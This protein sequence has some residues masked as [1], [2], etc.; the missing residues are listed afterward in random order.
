MTREKERLRYKK[1]IEL[2]R[3]YGL[4]KGVLGGIKGFEDYSKEGLI[5][6]LEE[7]EGILK[8]HLRIKND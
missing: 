1:T 6:V 7:V 2:M 4:I 3:A 5:S 8:E